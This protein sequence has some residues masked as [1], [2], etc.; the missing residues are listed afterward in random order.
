MLV[1]TSLAATADAFMFVAL[2]LVEVDADV[3]VEGVMV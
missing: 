1:R 3:V 2:V